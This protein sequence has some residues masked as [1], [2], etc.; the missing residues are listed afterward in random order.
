M[1][2]NHLVI[3]CASNSFKHR[4]EK[5]FLE[6]IDNVVSDYVEELGMDYDNRDDDS[7]NYDERFSWDAE[8]WRDNIIDGHELITDVMLAKFEE[9]L[10]DSF[11]EVGEEIASVGYDHYGMGHSGWNGVYEFCGMY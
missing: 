2:I 7:D 6:W 3:S 8:E 4:H 11:T 5:Q 1:A 9:L 10:L